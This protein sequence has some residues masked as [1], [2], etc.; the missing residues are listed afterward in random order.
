[1]DSTLRRCIALGAA[2]GAAACTAS[3]STDSAD[4]KET[5]ADEAAISGGNVSARKTVVVVVDPNDRYLCTAVTVRSDV[6]LTSVGCPDEAAAVY[7]GF[8]A[9]VSSDAPLGPS[10]GTATKIAVTRTEPVDLAIGQE[11]SSAM[12]LRLAS[13]ASFVATIAPSPPSVGA[14][15]TVTGY[16]PEIGNGAFIPIGTWD[17]GIQRSAQMKITTSGGAALEAIGIN[18]GVLTGDL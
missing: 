18:G 9:S 11:W 13:P 2:L 12:L 5:A 6:V 4:A 1:L 7:V 8:S 17:V 14:T 3:T 10:A 16:G 15:C